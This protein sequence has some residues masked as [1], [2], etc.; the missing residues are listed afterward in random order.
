M[1]VDWLHQA[2]HADAL[3]VIINPGAYSH[4]SLAL[5]DAMTAIDVPVVEVHI[6]NVFA[7]DEARHTLVTA[8]A[9][10]GL[11]AGFGSHGYLLAL[12]ALARRA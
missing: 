7:R 4:S 12:E 2:H 9:S 10:E 3:G 6:S 1:L 8:A 5:R 11:I